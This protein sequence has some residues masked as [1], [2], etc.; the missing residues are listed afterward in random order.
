[1]AGEPKQPEEI[2]KRWINY[3]PLI[4]LNSCSRTFH[5]LVDGLFSINLILHE[6]I[7]GQKDPSLDKLEKELT[8]TVANRNVKLWRISGSNC[9]KKLLK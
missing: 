6:N 9:S 4:Y 2:R 3:L 8:P 1:M 7:D 5:F